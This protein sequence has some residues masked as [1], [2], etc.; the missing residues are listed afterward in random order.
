MQQFEMSRYIDLDLYHAVE[1]THPYYIEMVSRICTILGDQQ[2][3]T[4]QHINILEVGAGT[5]L[6]TEE[7]LKYPYLKVTALE[8][9]TACCDILKRLAPQCHV[10]QGDAV[11]YSANQPMDAIVST[12]AHDHI[13]FDL[14]YEFAKNL[15]KNLKKGGLYIMGGEI[16]PK[17]TDEIGRVESLYR[18]HTFIVNKALREKHFA[19]AQIEINALE[20]GI[21]MT[22]DFKRHEAMFEE[23]MLSASF[24]LISKEKMGP[25]EYEDLG[26]VFVY[27]FEAI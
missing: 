17:F 15:R 11:T 21:K 14:R 19:L 10:V 18:Y 23:E 22:G 5:G 9:D 4:T 13:H 26:G 1:R 12:F 16:L 8:Y 6:M 3:K 27:V 24:K 2:R 25:I 7:L 20:S